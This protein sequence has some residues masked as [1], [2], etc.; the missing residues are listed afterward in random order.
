MGETESQIARGVELN[1]TGDY[2][3][4]VFDYSVYSAGGLS[5]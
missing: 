2:L 4:E 1:K 5:K 3:P